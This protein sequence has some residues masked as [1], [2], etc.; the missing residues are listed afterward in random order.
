MNQITTILFDMDGTLTDT[1]RLQ[2]YLVHQYL[3]SPSLRKKL[4]FQDVQRRLAVIYYMN[5][6]SWFRLSSFPLFARQFNISYIRLLVKTPVLVMQYWR[7]LIARERV[8]PGVKESLQLLKEN[9]ITTGLV[10]NGTDFEVTKKFKT[11]E[12]LFDV[13]VTASDVT[14]KKPDP[15][16]ILKGMKKAGST[17]GQTL[18]VGDTLVDMK[19]AAN[20]GCHFALV[21]TGTFGP[22]VVRIGTK[23]PEMVFNSIKE[24]VDHV[25]SGSNGS[26]SS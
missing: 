22:A 20:A 17:P 1:M 3:I 18:Y 12:N 15:E 21:A 23:K 14:R 25:I 2:P 19:A 10:T 5:R 7:A 26:F 9:K 24:L 6:Y 13:R 11:M 16:M 8:F 4:S